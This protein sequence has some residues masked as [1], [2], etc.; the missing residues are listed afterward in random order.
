MTRTI[1]S[2]PAR[3]AEILE[4]AQRLFFGVGYERAT[5][6][7]LLAEVGISKG[8]FYHHFESKEAVLMALV[9]ELGAQGVEAISPIL[10]DESL[11]PTGKLNAFF[12]VSRGFKAERAPLI[13]SM[14]RAMYAPSNVA[15]REALT[16]ENI[17]RIAPLLAQIIEQ[18]VGQGQMLSEDARASAQLVLHMSAGF[19]GELVRALLELDAPSESH[20]H[21]AR[22]VLSAH[23]EVLARGLERFLGMDPESLVLADEAFVDALNEAVLEES[24]RSR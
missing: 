2:A 4:V 19:N 8:A 6:N 24:R 21:A 7:D 1:K 23:L 17:A 13:I 9:S 10:A 5:V 15:L 14:M 22:E 16:Q 18:G 12:A 3:R 20:T 11:D